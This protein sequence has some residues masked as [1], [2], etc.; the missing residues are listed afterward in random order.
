MPPAYYLI[1]AALLPLVG[2]TLLIFLGKRFG[3]LAGPFASLL[4]IGSFALSVTALVTWVAKPEFNHPHYV[5][6]VTYRWLPLPADLLPA[7]ASQDNPLTLPIPSSSHPANPA[8][9][10]GFL[11]DSLT[12]TLFLM[13]SLLSFLVHIFSIPY[14]AA[15]P[16][17]SRY[18]AY[19]GLFSFAI[20]SLILSNSLIQILLCWQ[21]IGLSSYLLIGFWFENRRPALASFKSAILSRIGDASFL[22]GL[23]ILLMHAGPNGLTLFDSEGTSLLVEGVRNS[24][25]MGSSEFLYITSSGGFLGLH[26]LTWAGLALF[27]GA[28]AK[29]AQF[30][31]HV[32]L[33]DATEAPAPAA[34]LLFAG[35]SIS[36]GVYLIA[37]IYPILTMDARLVIAVIGCVTLLLGS[38]TALVQTDI[39]RLLAYS[40]LSQVGYM[41]LF[42]GAGGYVPGLL[43]LFT[44]AFFSTCLFLSAASVIYALNHQSHLEHMGGLWKKLPVTAATS[45]IALLAFIGVPWLS[46]A[47]SKNMGLAVV[48]DYAEALVHSASQ[49]HGHYA[50]LL[51]WIPALTSYLTAFYMGR[52]WWLTFGGKPRNEDLYEEAQESG[53][54]TFP[55]IVLA[56]LSAAIWFDFFHMPQLLEKSLLLDKGL[57]G[58]ILA[59]NPTDDLTDRMFTHAG[60]ILHFL[61]PA[62]FALL[63][64]PVYY[65]GFSLAN[66]LRKFPVLNLIHLWLRER[67]FLDALYNGIL[68]SA[69]LL[70]SQI[71]AFVDRSLLNPLLS[72]IPFTIRLLSRFASRFDL[73]LSDLLLN[74]LP[75]TPISLPASS[76]P[77][78]LTLPV[79]LLKQQ[80]L[81]LAAALTIAAVLVLLCLAALP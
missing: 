44:H 10:I 63:A 31:L 20:L 76:A 70:L 62:L 79:G 14:M 55:L 52:F 34:A 73:L 78:P 29:S 15:D 18:F 13:V 69:T 48:Y 42:L 61:P 77:N 33:P 46:G 7:T 49:G 58:K 71:A 40:A 19:L 74:R 43:H 12:I 75:H 50:L 56:I 54:M 65:K 1:L 26:W 45:L 6:A 27:G 16:R 35:T 38:L 72:L 36:A 8:L 3:R 30:P 37:R 80:K 23:G 32:W 68:G 47:Y 41:F 57:L 17:Q 28:V 24:L 4:L 39:K 22:I 81:M 2:F 64:I 11:V 51:F 9:S 21:L 66:R 67:M 5:E 59:I 53:L 60:K 25:N